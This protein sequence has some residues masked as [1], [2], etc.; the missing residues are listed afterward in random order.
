MDEKRLFE[1]VKRILAAGNNVEIRKRPD[2]TWQVLEVKKH[3]VA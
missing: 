3:T 1:I 2:G